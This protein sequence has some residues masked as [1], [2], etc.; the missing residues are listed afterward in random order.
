MKTRVHQPQIQRCPGVPKYSRPASPLLSLP[1]GRWGIVPDHV[2]WPRMTL[3]QL[4][5]EVGRS[6]GVAVP[7]QF[8]PFHFARLQAHRRVVLAFSPRWGL[9]DSTSAGSPCSTYLSLNSVPARKW[10]QSA[11]NFLP[12]DSFAPRRR[13]R[14]LP[15]RPPAW[16]HLYGVPCGGGHHQ[17]EQHEHGPGKGRNKVDIPRASLNFPEFPRELRAS[18]GEL[19]DPVPPPWRGLAVRL[20]RRPGQRGQHHAPTGSFLGRLDQ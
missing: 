18:V 7:L 2:H 8:H 13:H 1:K 16:P 19:Y 9:V 17:P 3:M 20:T 15:R 6:S 14:T 10:A 12:P 4:S 11:K 5:Q